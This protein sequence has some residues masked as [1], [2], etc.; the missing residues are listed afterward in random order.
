MKPMTWSVIP[1]HQEG[2]C[3]SA[4]ECKCFMHGRPYHHGQIAR[5]DCNEWFVLQILHYDL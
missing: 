2:R 4:G 5:Q 3:V 1:V